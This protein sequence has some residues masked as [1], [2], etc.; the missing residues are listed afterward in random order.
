M[1]KYIITLI[2]K[3]TLGGFHMA[4]GDPIIYQE[5]ELESYITDKDFRELQ[6]T[7]SKRNLYILAITDVTGEK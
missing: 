7:Y 6:E 3:V 5:L 2:D 1:R 4:F